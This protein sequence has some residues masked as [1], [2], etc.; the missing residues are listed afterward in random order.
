MR[1][2]LPPLAA[3]ALFGGLLNLPAVWGGGGALERFLGELAGFE[4]HASHALEWWLAG[5][6]AVIF[7]IG[8][9]LAHWRYMPF[10]GERP[11][12]LKSFLLRGWEADRLVRALFVR[13]FNLLARFFWQSDVRGIDGLLEGT[14]RV[15]MKLGGMLRRTATGRLHTY[16]GG[17]AW[18]LLLILAWM[19]VDFIGTR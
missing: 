9:S 4:I 13:P 1:W 14:G 8:W 3:L 7:S 5:A 19:L 15:I 16:L 11:G 18:G 2:T 12:R 17:F 6:A 10:P